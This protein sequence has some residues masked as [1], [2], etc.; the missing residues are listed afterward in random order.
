MVAGILAAGPRGPGRRRQTRT[1]APQ[2]TGATRELD[3]QA[4]APR[5]G[6]RSSLVGRESTHTWR[7]RI[8]EAREE[9]LHTLFAKMRCGLILRQTACCSGREHSAGPPKSLATGAFWR[10][11]QRGSESWRLSQGGGGRGEEP[12]PAPAWACHPEAGDDQGAS[13]NGGQRH[14]A[15]GSQVTECV[16]PEVEDQAPWRWLRLGLQPRPARWGQRSE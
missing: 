2:V 13:V 8:A 10:W 5:G 11:R 4:G 6:A 9:A 1:Q 15:D 14:G 12:G 3:G 7:F 16:F